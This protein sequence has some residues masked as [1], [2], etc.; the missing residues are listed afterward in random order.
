[1]SNRIKGKKTQKFSFS[2]VLTS[3]YFF[4]N[5]QAFF[6]LF[7]HVNACA[8]MCL[9][10]EIHNRYLLFHHFRGSYW[11]PPGFEP[12]TFQVPSR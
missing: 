10:V 12:L 7:D 1:M 6:I 2:Y 3:K 8:S 5:F 9:L 4:G 11:T